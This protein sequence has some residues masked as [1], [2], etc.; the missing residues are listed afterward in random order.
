MVSI[1]VST[2]LLDHFRTHG[3]DFRSISKH[4]F[5]T[6]CRHLSVISSQ[7][8]SL[9]LSEKDDSP[10]QIDR[11][12]SHGFTL[13]QFTHL[14]SLSLYHLHS[15]DT[16]NKILLDLP[17]LSSITHLT[18]EECCF[19]YDET[20][21]LTFV[22]IIWSLPKLTHCYINIQFK[23]QICFPIPKVI[24][25]TIE[26]LSIS[27]IEPQFSQMA[28]LLENTPNL[29]HLSIDFH[30]NFSDEYQS[31]TMTSVNTWNISFFSIEYHIL[32]N[33]LK[34][35]PN[36]HQLK[37]DLPDILPYAFD[38]F[39]FQSPILSKSTCH[40]DNQQ[41]PYNYVRRL[42]YKA[43]LFEWSTLSHIQFNRIQELCVYLPINEYF[44]SIIPRL[45]R[46]TILD[47]LSNDDIENCDIQLQT[48]LDRIP[49]VSFL[50]LRNWSSTISQM[51]SIRKKILSLSQLDLM[52]CKWY[53]HEECVIL[54][55]LLLDVQCKVLLI[56]VT[57]RA[58]ILELVN[59]INNLPAVNVRCQDDKSNNSSTLTEDELIKWLQQ[60]LQSSRSITRDYCPVHCIQLWIR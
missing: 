17:Y 44:W 11:F 29:R 31:S 10:G 26:H 49:H 12:Y 52:W 8:T 23:P 38:N 37:V 1:L 41:W 36:L 58:C 21:A 7:I 55:Q 2:L 9:Y 48:L 3:L 50:R 16:M 35:M 54:N 22:I 46:L 57:N 15:Q 43:N 20:D 30:F 33:F 24:S 39:Y 27:D 4:N 25:S 47:V 42:T 40:Y 18:F 34:C 19:T 6:I 59:T 5:Y 56:D 53:N 32:V 60:Y 13:R 14:Q 45:E 51:L 28:R